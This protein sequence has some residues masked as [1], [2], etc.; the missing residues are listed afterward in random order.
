M[1]RPLPTIRDAE[2]L[3]HYLE[4]L[5]YCVVQCAEARGNHNDLFLWNA[6]RAAEAV[7]FALAVGTELAKEFEGKSQ[8]GG[9]RNQVE[10]FG[11]LQSIGR[12]SD[13]V[14]RQLG[15][16]WAAGCLG[17][18]TQTPERV[19]DDITLK[20]CESSLHLVVRW[21]YRDSVLSRPLSA[22]LD[23]ALHDLKGEVKRPTP[24]MKLRWEFDELRKR[25]TA[26]EAMV[27][28]RDTT[29]DRPRLVQRPA[30]R[31]LTMGVVSFVAGVGIGVAL[32]GG[33]ASVEPV[34]VGP[35][36]LSEAPASARSPESAPPSVADAAILSAASLAPAPLSPPTSAVRKRRCKSEQRLFTGTPPRFIEGPRPRPDWPRK[37]A[38]PQPVALPPFC[39]DRAPV[40][41]AS[42]SKHLAQAGLARGPHHRETHCNLGNESNALPINC[43]LWTEAQRYCE[44]HGGRLPSILQWEAAMRAEPPVALIPYTGEWAE[45]AF[46]PTVFGYTAEPGTPKQRLYWEK[47]LKGLPEGAPWLSW[48]RKRTEKGATNLSFRCASDPHE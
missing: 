27:R 30:F 21:L 22:D 46:P 23:S 14:V 35:G 39:L 32:T 6:R 38:I 18:H 7:G 29:E 41:T 8:S 2:R 26:L 1:S 44:V 17:A 13:T 20:A 34:G 45:D 16:V 28:S 31:T 36:I 4:I 47:A 48:Q 5:E 33:A 10:L 11:K 25:A 12:L 19:V 37:E 42:F 24:E 3:E 15:Q 43:S 40:T 9:V